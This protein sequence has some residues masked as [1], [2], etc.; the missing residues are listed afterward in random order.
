VS[1]SYINKV[2]L[3]Q[4]QVILFNRQGAKRPIYHMRIH[5]RG[6]RDVHGNRLTYIQES[7]GEVDLDEAKRV[8]LDRYDELRLRVRD[9][10][11]AKDLSFADMYEL[12]WVHKKKALEVLH[13]E[14]GRKGKSTRV[15]WYEKLGARYW[16]KYFGDMKI[17]AINQSYVQGYWQWRID[18][19]KNAS[20]EERKRY[21]N[22]ALNP[23]KKSLDMEQ[24]VLREI[25]GWAHANRL[26][27]YLPQIA[28]PY[29][30][31]GISPARRP[32]FE[33]QEWQRLQDYMTEW[34]Q[35]RGVNDGGEGSRINSA[36]LYRRQLLRLYVLWLEGTGLRTG[37]ANE[38][39]H[40]HI[41]R[42]RT[43][44]TQTITLQIT[45]SPQTKTGARLVLPQQSA[46]EAYK[47]ICELTGHTD[48]DDWLFCAKDG[49]KLKGFYK[50]LDK[51]LDEIGL[52]YDENGDKRTMYSFRHLYA[53]NRLRQLGSTPQAFDLLS[54]NMGTS[55][56]MIEQ[57][58][59]RKGILYDEDLI[60]GVSKKD[61]ERVRRLDAERDNDE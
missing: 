27:K 46:V 56:Q 45:V 13:R 9:D 58:Y 16:L 14:K 51:M 33:P 3:K 53:E 47:A 60:S 10:A 18:Y 44:S 12:W 52:L 61:I 26:V 8:A 35:G 40:K 54:T 19:W 41:K 57:H 25:F 55:R 2:E 6:M 24:S 17:D 11:P 49:K 20:A 23:K 48:G 36:H 38:L 43:D 31:K 1:K 28:N 50:T 37:E 5:V 59:V 29:H 7:T 4:G 15:S 42:F 32:S 22:H 30:R 39:K 21:A 34:A